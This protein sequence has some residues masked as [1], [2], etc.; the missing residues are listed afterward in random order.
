MRLLGCILARVVGIEGAL[1]AL[2]GLVF[3]MIANQGLHHGDEGARDHEEIVVE[4]ADQFQNR[5]VARHDLPGL[6]AGDVPL[7]ETNATDQ[8]S[9]GPSALL[10]RLLQREAHLKREAIETK[11]FDVLFC[12]INHD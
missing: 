9:L 10:A 7:G 8:V 12:I 3:E 1:F 6:D 11:H 4:N 2:A 5:V